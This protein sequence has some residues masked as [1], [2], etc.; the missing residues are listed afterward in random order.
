M[1][2]DEKRV[3]LHLHSSVSDGLF[4]PAELVR[5]A[6]AAGLR[7]IALTD[8]DEVGGIEEALRAGK[9]VGIEVVPGIE[10]SCEGG[11][12]D[13]HMLGFFVD[14]RHPEIRDYVHWYHE[15]RLQ[16]GRR[17]VQRLAELGIHLDFA[18]LVQRVGSG[19]LGRPHIADALLQHGYVS[20]IAEA[21]ERYLGDGRPAYVPKRKLS[22]ADAVELIH[23]AGGLAVLAHPGDG[24]SREEVLRAIELGIDGLEAVHPRHSAENVEW[25]RKIARDHGLL[26]TG[27]SDFHGRGDEF[28]LGAL[29]VFWPAYQALVEARD[30]N[31]RSS[32][33]QS[34]TRGGEAEKASTA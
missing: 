24:L 20:S 17:M 21:F 28:L 5:K 19:A 26:E 32:R 2:Q 9:A 25:I 22:P 23:R 15:E 27:G 33:V 10:I 18:E 30:K 3:D 6:A 1:G 31:R 29:D 16:R 12:L 4:G 14:P 8:H 7:A 11:S 13:V 34:N